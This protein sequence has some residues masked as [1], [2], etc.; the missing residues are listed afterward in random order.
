MLYGAL[1]DLHGQVSPCRSNFLKKYHDPE[2]PV[3]VILTEMKTRLNWDE[4][5]STKSCT[6]NV[7]S[8]IHKPKG[9]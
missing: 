8:I 6:Q 2:I 4:N 1:E 7:H 3:L 9:I 5:V